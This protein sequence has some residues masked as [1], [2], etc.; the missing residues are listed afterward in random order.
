MIPAPGARLGPYEILSA[1]GAGGMGEVWRARDPRLGREVAIKVLPA[2]AVGDPDRLA[3]LEREARLLAS[4]NHPN[5]ATLHAFEHEDGIRFLVMEV[6]EGQNLGERLTRGPLPVADALDFFRQVADGLAAAHRKGIVHRDLKPANLQMAPG[7]LAKI[8]DFGLATSVAPAGDVTNSPTIPE[9]HT[10]AGVIMGTAPYMAPEQAKGRPADERSDIFSFGVTLYEALTGRRAFPGESAAEVLAAVLE[11]EPDWSTLPGGTPDLV[12][13]LLRRCLKKN[14]DERLRDISEA[15]ALLSEAVAPAAAPTPPVAALVPGAP[16]G[17]GWR[18]LAAGLGALALLSAGFFIGRSISSG[19]GTLSPSEARRFQ[20]ESKIEGAPAISPDGRRI[21]YAE[22]GRRRLRDLDRLD[23][24]EVPGSENGSD[25][26]WSPDGRHLAFVSGGFLKRAPMDGGPVRTICELKPAGA[27]NLGSAWG[28]AGSIVIALGPGHGLFEVSSEGGDLKPLL[29]RDPAKG[30]FDVH[31]PSFLPD[32]R[33][34]LLVVHPETGFNY[35][36][37]IFDGRG[38]RR[39]LPESTPPLEGPV[40]CRSGHMLF[41]RAQGRP[42]LSAVPLD[43]S[44]LTV[45]GEAIQLAEDAGSPSVSDNGTLV[46]VTGGS[47]LSDLV[48]VNRSGRL[49]RT[50]SAGHRDLLF[51]RVSPDG[52]RVMFSEVKDGNYDVWVEDIGKGSRVRLTT[53]PE[54]DMAGAWASSGERVTLMS[55]GWTDSGVILMRADGSGGAERPPFRSNPLREADHSS[56]D[57]SPDGRFVIFQSEGNLLYADVTDKR[58]PA[59]FVTSPFMESEGRFSPDGRYVAYMS[60]ESG[61]FEVYVRPF[62]EGDRKWALSTNGGALP[63]WSRR[64]DELFYAE[65]DSLMAV[66]VSTR[67]GF[68]SSPPK[69]LFDAAALGLSAYVFDPLLAA[70]DPLPDG[71]GFVIVQ[72]PPRGQ[73]KIVV[74]E[75]WA[76]ELKQR[77]TVPRVP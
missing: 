7:G 21:A 52:R 63:R 55:G 46:Y 29:K 22:G 37:A 6:V 8:L 54:T 15:R 77:L 40:Y 60:N 33:T 70:Y 35:F 39:L 13:F 31:D 53:G 19:T 68:R 50:I 56:P 5:I 9:H 26:F 3:R 69:K 43:P 12:R 65:G 67:G 28:P 38:I 17:S 62:P 10:A 72:R 18:W 42:S 20:I 73:E 44:T 36:A 11:R 2:G 64:G 48:L 75:N 23:S 34:L 57:W 76:A 66:S 24:R 41:G 45:T 58:A 74:V 16:P 49:E 27:L 30:I 47:R 59:T 51:P 61:R 4:L 1:I 14:P 25:P 32:G 71:Q